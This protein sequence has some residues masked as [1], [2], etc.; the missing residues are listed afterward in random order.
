M[1]CCLNVIGNEK[2]EVEM[3]CHDANYG[4]CLYKKVS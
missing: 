4:T 1:I 2:L 3:N